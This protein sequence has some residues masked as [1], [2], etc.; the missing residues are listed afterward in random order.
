MHRLSHSY[1][2]LLFDMKKIAILGSTGSI[3]TQTLKVISDNSNKLCVHSL[4]AFSNESLL[5]QQAKQY[6]ASYFATIS[7]DG[8]ACLIDAVKGCDI[9]VI[10][11][12]GIVA[13]DAVMYCID[14]NIDIAIANK[15]VLV[16][17][18]QLVMDRLKHSNSRLLPIDS[19]HSAIWQCIYNNDNAI[20]KLYLTASGGALY[21]FNKEQLSMATAQHCLAHPTWNMGQKI[22][23]DSAT[24][25]NKAL[26]VVEAHWLFGVDADNIEIVIHRQS[27]VHSMVKFCDNSILAQLSQP[28]MMLPIQYAL[29]YPYR[30]NACVESLDIFD[31]PNLT[32][33]RVD[34][35]RFPC[36][37]LGHIMLEHGGLVPTVVNACNDICVEQ[38]ISG[39]IT[40]DKIYSTIMH[41]LDYFKHS[42]HNIVVTVESIKRIDSDVRTYV[43]NYLNGA[44]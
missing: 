7:K 42:V 11:T 18:G 41:T 36:A 6:N 28:N 44:K 27:I 39:A 14:N 9:A 22:T 37:T 19:E 8:A 30:A 34:Y 4:V 12:R 32:F 2:C 15:E 35:D 43:A 16:T 25:M 17:A 26:E 23:I 33:R 24:M 29:L 10:A 38:Y 40:F 5:T 1:I 31:M 13:L 21:D 20:S 3:G